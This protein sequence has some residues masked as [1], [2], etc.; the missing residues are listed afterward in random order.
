M[1]NSLLVFLLL[2][3]SVKGYSQSCTLSVSI[4]S[5]SP[6]ICS[7]TSAVLTANPSAGTAPYSYVWNTGETTQTISVN[8]T[9]TYTVTVSDKTPGCQ[10]VKQSIVITASVIPPA[11]T[12]PG[13]IVCQNSPATLTATA[14]GGTY[15]WY[16]ASTGGNF[17][18]SGATF[19]TPPVTAPIIYYVQTTISSCASSRTPVLVSILGKPTVVGATVC[20]GN[21]ANLSASGGDSYVWYDAPTG[22]NVVSTT[23]TFTTPP[24]LNTTTYYVVSTTSGCVSA[25]TPV[26]A[27]VTPPPQAPTAASISICSGNVA[28]LHATA[29]AGIFDW[30]TVPNGGTSLISSPDYTT[31]PLTTTTTYYVQT[32]LNGCVSSRTPVTVTVNS[33][34]PAPTVPAVSTCYGTSA[35][36]TATAPGGTYQWYD[37]PAGGNLLA[38]G[39]TFNT[40]AIT[41]PTTYYVQVTSGGGCTSTRTAVTVSIL[42][43]VPS[44][45]ASD[46]LVCSGSSTTLTTTGPGG[47]YQWYDAATGGNLLATNASYTTP[48][49]TVTTTYYVQTT[50]AGCTSARTPITVTI[51]PITPA[52]TAP[53]TTVC[54]GNAASLTATGGSGN[55]G[56]YDSLTGG[57]LL[58][59]GQVYVT[60]ALTTTTTYYVQ[61]T[62]VN[63][64]ASPRTP[65]IVIVDPIPTAPTVSGTT[66]CPNT[67]ATLT[68]SATGT[69]QWYDAATAGN[70]LATGA[71]FTTPGLSANTTY[72]VQNTTGSC[73]SPRTPVTVN[74]ISV[75]NPQFKYPSGTI[76]A[77]GA[78]VT[79][80]INNPSGGTF[81]ASPAGLVF[82][83]TTTGQINVAASVPGNYLISFAGGGVCPRTTSAQITL[84]SSPNAQFSYTGGT[85]C[86][87]AT[88]P[89]PV[90]PAGSSGGVFTAAPAG[91]VFI[92][93]STGEIDLKTSAAGTFTITNTIASSGG[94]P[95]SVF[96]ASVTINQLVTVSAG[97][98]QTVQA[99]NTVQLAGS[100]SGGI[101][102]GTW[103]GGTGTFSNPSLPNAVY[104][105]G[106]GETSA[107]LTLTSGDPPGPCGPASDKVTITI[108]PLPPAP[109]APGQSV[110]PGTSATLSAIAP[111]GAY[112]WF[113]AAT[114]GTL[115]ASGPSYATPPLIVNTTYYVQTTIGGITSPRT[116]VLVTITAVPAAPAASGSAVCM[117]TPATLTATGSAGSYAWYDAPVGGNLLSANNTYTTP[118]LTVPTSYY[119]EA[120]VN[121]C[122]STRTKVDVTITPAPNV[123]SVSTGSVCSGSAENYTITADIPASTFSWSRAAVPGIS[124]PAVVNQTSG[125]ITETLINT[126]TTPIN[127]TYVIT[128]FANGCTGQSFSYVVIVNPGPTVTSP[129][130][131]T[132]CSATSAD[133]TITFSTPIANLTWSRAAVTGI[134][135]APVSGQ[136]ATT[137]REVLFNT[138]SAP[139]D[140]TYVF[141]YTT[142]SCAGSQ[143]DLVITVD[144]LSRI[145]SATTGIACSGTPQNYTLT[146][147]IPTATFS[148]DRPAVAGISNP[149]VVGQTS[150]VINETL[151]NTT[152]HNIIVTYTL[153]AVANG[154]PGPTLGYAVTVSPQPPTP[155]ANGNSPVCINST[156]QLKAPTVPNATY[157]W[158]GPN[159][160]SSTQQNPNI[161]NITTA[162]SGI[163]NLFVIINGCTSQGSPVTIVVDDFPKSVAGPNQ[164]VCHNT[165]GVQLAG[166]E[167][168]GTPTG[169]WSTSGTGT[170]SPSPN[171]LDAIYVPSA[172]DVA[173]GGV[174][175]TLTSTSKDDCTL[176]FDSMT[177]TFQSAR[178]T[179]ASTGSICNGTAQNYVI[180]SSTPSSTFT[181]SR[182]AVA[183]ISNAAVSNVASGT[184]DETLIN[185]GTTPIDVAYTIIPTDA[186][187]CPGTPFTYT[188]TVN[189]T[190]PAPVASVKSP[191]CVNS[192]I[193]LT[194]PTV[195]NATYSWTGPAG[196]ASPLQ[197]PTITNATAANAGTYSLIR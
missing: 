101:T 93:N 54:S 62:S 99:G 89:L 161:T 16:D 140:V 33:I 185:T 176:S 43:Q 152:T 86:Q 13:V 71:T 174:Q 35:A 40:P 106:P 64:C 85:F 110:C 83:S 75:A 84:S 56:W 154:C 121:S 166:A 95:A 90:F 158:T 136:A 65:V 173:A 80:V 171:Q 100:I 150:N 92:N 91:L 180:T 50:I 127:V 72:Y 168:G 178:V 10:P 123:T 17:L 126:G 14:P 5:P 29:P 28:N 165:A 74:I 137:V 147:D 183:G 134:S 8:K 117:N 189:P 41:S 39:V 2:L 51:L 46:P 19:V 45:T 184:I 145:T 82:V 119:V 130:A 155:V 49:L 73:P 115:L 55:F 109:T 182:P 151:I 4:S 181:Y 122:V 133:Y 3:I 94:C 23:S 146:A 179:S 120:I 69:I 191:V 104:T 132:I 26:V 38:T 31:P 47:V 163:Y 60:P 25:P 113:D 21:T 172:A 186:A 114:G 22:G 12:A 42:P 170:F 9:G 141:T 70:L 162:N 138:T 175:L 107:T 108:N 164:I 105:P 193:N 188:V 142:G 135:N 112:K 196:F 139:I 124:N 157:M 97:P 116:A 53:G 197:N 143:F 34:P 76:C 15:Q 187:G 57:T 11:P 96:T 160:Y 59:A 1:K 131:A 7:G 111:G 129:A 87:D 18:A 190:P 58:S 37:A 118:P 68:A 125:S 194:T 32:S 177:I 148:W 128:P 66:I 103:S 153:S 195:A 63:G 44:P 144:P 77:S 61:S 52:P 98:N 79:P 24:L 81:S 169:I 6:A 156:I 67:T 159:G 36:V 149:P 192:V 48:A 30:F 27:K 20:Q 102:T 78:N 88:D 167:T